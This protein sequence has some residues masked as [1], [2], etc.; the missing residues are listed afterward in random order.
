[1]IARRRSSL[2]T[3]SFGRASKHST[4]GQATVEFALL[5]PAIA[6]IVLLIGQALL[7]GHDMLHVANVARE[8]ARAAAVDPSDHDAID[9]VKRELPGA[10]LTVVRDGRPGALLRAKVRWQAPTSLPIVGPLL[11]DPWLETTVTMRI[12]Q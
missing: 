10:Q 3:R 4:S 8:A 11:P 2:S 7:I 9:V 6:L 12:E 5:L 1:M